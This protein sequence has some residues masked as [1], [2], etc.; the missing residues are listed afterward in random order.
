MDLQ[1]CKYTNQ[2]GRYYGIWRYLNF[3]EKEWQISTYD[4]MDEL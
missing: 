2:N 4:K 1:M 3:F